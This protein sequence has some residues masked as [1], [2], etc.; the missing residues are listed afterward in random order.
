MLAFTS[1]ALFAA[2]NAQKR[3]PAHVPLASVPVSFIAGIANITNDQ[4]TKVSAIED[5]LRTDLASNKMSTDTPDQKRAKERDLRN[6]A[7]T[8]M[9]AALT[10]EEI[11][12]IDAAGPALNRIARL[13]AGRNVD[14]LNLTPDQV[15]KIK[16]LADDAN[17]KEKQID[18][19]FRTQVQAL[20]TPAQQGALNTTNKGNKR[21]GA[22]RNKAK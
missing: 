7:N 14:A 3:A 11:S 18:D 1:H 8:D 10:P 22:R 2:P 6:Q 15:Q 19:D 13:V 17:A 20:L 5:K 4:K 16:G 9:S 21:P 12:A